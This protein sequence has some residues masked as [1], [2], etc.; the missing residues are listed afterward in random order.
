M[1]Y[2]ARQLQQMHRTH[3]RIVLPY[4]A[5]LTP[6]ARDWVKRS[7]VTIGY[8]ECALDCANK[9]PDAQPAAAASASPLL[10]WCDGP[11]GTVKAAIVTVS[12]QAP[13]VE[14][15][16]SA[17]AGKVAAAVQVIAESVKQGAAAGGVIAVAAGAQAM[18]LANRCP[19]LR[20][21]LGTSLEAVE[22][23]IEQIAAN[24]LVLEH[25][26]LTLMQARNMLQH[27]ARAKRQLSEDMK[28]QLQVMAGL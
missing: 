2:T 12:K 5:R 10:W 23:G 27:F 25:P 17:D 6:M 20:A 19:Q 14:M 15:P 11:C 28:R 8:A 22:A 7:G 21:V 1:F 9:Q 26:R 13:L 4:R 24:V 18:L 3:G 16:L